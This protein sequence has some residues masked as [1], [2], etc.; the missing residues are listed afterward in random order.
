MKLVPSILVAMNVPSAP[1]GFTTGYNQSEKAGE[2][3]LIDHA[4]PT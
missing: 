2:A 1:W 4:P 3:W